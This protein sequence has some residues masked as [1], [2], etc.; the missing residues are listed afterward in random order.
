MYRAHIAVDPH[1][2]QSRIQTCTDHVRSVAQMTKEHLSPFGLSSTGELAGLLH[3]L[4]KF[5]TEF[6]SY[7]DKAS[8]GEKV[9]KGSVIHTFSGVRYLLEHFHS[10]NDNSAFGA[11]TAELIAISI[12]SHHG[13][14]DLWD[15]HHHSGFDHRLNQQPDYDKHAIDAFFAECASA[16]MLDALFRQ[17]EQEISHFYTEKLSSC[18]HS[19]DEAH[20]AL[21]LLSRLLTSAVVDADRTDTRCFME[22]VPLPEDA[23]LSWDAC[24]KHIDAHINGFPKGSPIQQARGVFSDSCAAAAD[25]TPGLYRLDLPTGG[26][27]TL[28]A[29]R[30]AVLHARKHHMHRIFYIAP[31]LSIIEQ[32]AA[33]IREAVGDTIPVLE[34][35]SNIIREQLSTEEA[36]RTELLQETWDAP[37]IVTTLVQL[38]ETLFSGKMASV[39]RFHC[40]YSSVIIIDEVQSLPSKMLS[41][42]NCAIN[43]LT[44]CC[45]TT[46]I[47]CSAT[48]PAFDNAAVQHKMLPSTRLISTALYDHYAPLFQRTEIT[49]GGTC[50]L[51]ELAAVSVS[52]LESSSSLLIVCNTKRE[53]SR[54]YELLTDLTDAHLFHLSAGMCMAHRKHVLEKMTAA[55]QGGE[56]LIC[57]STQ[58]IEAGIDISF[59]SVIR[60]SAGLDNIVQA[61]GR[62]N[63]HGEHATPQPVRIFR[64][65]DEKLGPL[66]EITEAQTALSVLLQE[67]RRNPAFYSHDLTS[68]TAV[69][70]YY[71]SLYQNMPVGYQDYYTHGHT[72]FELLSGNDQ[73]ISD[74]GTPY[75]LNQAFR[76]AGEWFEVFD[77][78][79]ESVLVPYQEGASLI[80]LLA[81]A[82][83]VCD[84][85]R[86]RT[87]LTQAKPYTV[88]VSAN[89]IERML[90]NGMLCTL[91]NGSIYALNNGHYDDHTGIKEGNDSCSTLIL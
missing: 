3:D 36:A 67:Y 73:Y 58:V 39:R 40:L 82:D 50:S 45:G 34:H 71:A 18:V 2:S 84:I 7:L 90:K 63:R 79:S 16:D 41:L 61:A 13:L 88:S 26:G 55:L 47:L 80:S 30:F 23:P 78:A 42:F 75:L 53:A 83:Y 28:A 37:M 77:N 87:L 60:L 20:F 72:L 17:A 62:C 66:R 64:L 35:H 46:V 15:E 59:G 70:A 76:T 69:E 31:L 89:Q 11:L 91:L 12:G 54:L 65:K 38:L 24:A 48:Q 22:G 43:F 4:G 27:K 85:R 10:L 25:M 57:V 1:T 14:F 68:D 9:A 5:T 21:S 49:D 51:E 29:L 8:R 81:D 19:S 74:A 44:K 86:T 32:N 33:V 6:D 52:T 56:S